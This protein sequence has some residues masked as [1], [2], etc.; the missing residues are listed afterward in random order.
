MTTTLIPIEWHAALE[1]S[2][3]CMTLRRALADWMEENGEPEAAEA[4]RWS[5]EFNR[6]PSSR[7]HRDSVLWEWGSSKMGYSNGIPEELL[8][9]ASGF[10]HNATTAAQAFVRLIGKW[11]NST[12]EERLSYWQWQPQS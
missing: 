12:P 5:I 9:K 11:Q 2:P 10:N 1:A 8:Y 4:L 3:E 7:R 6:C